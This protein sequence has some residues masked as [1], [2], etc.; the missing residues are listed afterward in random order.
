MLKQIFH[1][2][3]FEKS[4]KSSQ[5]GPKMVSKWIR[6]R[7]R[8]MV[9]WGFGAAGTSSTFF[10]QFL[11][12]FQLIS[13]DFLSAFLCLLAFVRTFHARRCAL[14]KTVFLLVFYGVFVRLKREKSAEGF[15]NLLK[16]KLETFSEN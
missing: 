9:C 5:N 3:G 16:I 6:N 8:N 10:Q 7:S 1:D 13:G 2:M 12:D 14:A 15:E 11:Q 4:A